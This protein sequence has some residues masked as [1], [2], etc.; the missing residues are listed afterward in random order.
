VLFIIKNRL[1]PLQL[2]WCS[3]GLSEHCCRCYV[4]FSG[5]SLVLHISHPRFID[6][7]SIDYRAQHTSRA[8]TF[9]SPSADCHSAE[10]PSSVDI[11]YRLQTGVVII[12]I[13]VVFNTLLHSNS[14]ASDTETIF[15]RQIVQVI[16]ILHICH[17]LLPQPARENVQQRL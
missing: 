1:S 12:I 11:H 3:T 7:I 5:N 15:I 2:L 6:I 16:Y 8:F 9:A 4:K 13:W 17:P 14:F 10:P